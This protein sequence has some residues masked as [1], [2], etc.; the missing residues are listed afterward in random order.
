MWETDI[1]QLRG[2]RERL[3]E[4]P[5]TALTRDAAGRAA[6]LAGKLEALA[7]EGAA[8]AAAAAEIERALAE[9]KSGR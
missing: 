9:R 5:A 3:R 8:A 7:A 2:L 6:V 4:A 1:A